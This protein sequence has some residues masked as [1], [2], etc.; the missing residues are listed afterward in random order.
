MSAFIPTRTFSCDLPKV[1]NRLRNGSPTTCRSSIVWNTR[2]WGSSGRRASPKPIALVSANPMSVGSRRETSQPRPRRWSTKSTAPVTTSAIEPRQ[3]VPPH[4]EEP[5]DRVE[6][7]APVLR[8]LDVEPGRVHSALDLELGGAR[9]DEVDDGAGHRE[10][11]GH[12]LGGLCAPDEHDQRESD[13][14]ERGDR[15]REVRH[16]ATRS[17]DRELR[18]RATELLLGLSQR[19]AASSTAMS[20]IASV[21]AA[22]RTPVLSDARWAGTRKKYDLAASS[23]SLTG[24]TV[25]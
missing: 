17:E 21:M 5:D 11:G 19:D 15:K 13:Q 7:L 8:Q 3:Q 10:Q 25:M 12:H 22:S 6:R 18:R 2:T 24:R 4:E 1:R 20:S 14:R 23:S 9:G 16:V